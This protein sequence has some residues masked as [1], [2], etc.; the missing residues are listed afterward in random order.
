MQAQSCC[1]F[2]WEAGVLRPLDPLAFACLYFFFSNGAEFFK[3]EK[4]EKN[5]VC[6]AL[7]VATDFSSSLRVFWRL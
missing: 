4:S 6:F 2:A 3:G 5:C 7:V 1:W